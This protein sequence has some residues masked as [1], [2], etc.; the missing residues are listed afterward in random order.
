VTRVDLSGL[1]K[2]FRAGKQVIQALNDV[3]V[4]IADGE[5]MVFLGPSGSG[6][7]T[8]LRCLAGLERP[9]AGRITCGDRVLVDVEA[10]VFLPAETRGLAMVFQ[11]YALWPHMTVARN[12]GFGLKMARRS[13]QDSAAAI[14]EALRVVGLE[15]YGERRINELSGG[16]MQRVGLARA[17]AIDPPLV[18]MD[19][20]L[21]NLDPAIRLELRDELKQM[22]QTR[23]GTTIHVTHDQEEALFLADRV[24]VF[25]KGR[26][27]QCGNV[28][29]LRS[30]PSSLFV[31]DFLGWRNQCAVV[32]DG[33]QVRLAADPHVALINRCELSDERFADGTAGTHFVA[34]IHPDG[35]K[36]VGGLVP[37]VDGKVCIPATI[38][39]AAFYSGWQ[40]SGIVELD[41]GPALHFRE[42]SNA[43]RFSPG[44][45]VTVTVDQE[46]VRLFAPA[47]ADQQPD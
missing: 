20:P 1:S 40:A 4:D 8:A 29:D 39:T 15:G 35:V 34:A 9:D 13:P 30:R 38:V 43:G 23:G 7:T 25:S 36:V 19:E 5:Y 22:H 32:I 41:D 11:S 33:G 21:S 28:E 6:K 42:A 16:Q 14:A 44:D 3:S 27:E 24:T 2:S 45:R 31:A 37:P 12:V 10:G 46:M 47:P 18:L 26:I 17:I